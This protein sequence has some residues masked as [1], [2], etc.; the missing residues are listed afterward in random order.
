MD[1]GPMSA[2]ADPTDP[3]TDLDPVEAA[4][5]DATDAAARMPLDTPGPGCPVTGAGRPPRMPMRR[6]CP[7]DPP[8]EYR[9]LRAEAPVD[10]I[11][12]PSGDEGWLVSRLDL[13][14]EVLADPRVSHRN[15]LIEP[16]VPPQPSAPWTPTPPAPGS[17]NMMDPPEQTR[18]RKLLA[19]YF[20]SRRVAAH[21]DDT[22]RIAH[23]QL[24]ELRAQGPG[25]DLMAHYAVPLAGRVICGLL[26]V[27]D[28]E[29]AGLQRDVDTLFEITL[30]VERAIP[31]ITEF[32]AAVDR[33]VTASEKPDAGDALLADLAAREELD[34]DELRAVAGI[35]ISGGLD[36]TPG[37]LGL[38][39]LALMHHPDQVPVLLDAPEDAGWPVD[40]LLRYLTIS[41][42][43][44]S[45][46]VLEDIEVDGVTLRAGELVVLA[47][48][49]ANRDPGA[50]AEPDRLD[51]TR[52]PT[53]HVAFGHGVHQCL[54]Q[55][56]ARATLRVGW[57]TLFAAL[58][59]LAPAVDLDEV[60]LRDE[61]Q[62]YGPRELPVLWPG[63]R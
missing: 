20:S 18:L 59:D 7:F 57:R 30:T 49:A 27:P 60:S 34:G 22:R 62:H 38:G 42:W 15:D 8:E 32:G 19:R 25:A 40:E 58:P 54:G 17:F 23:E 35:L 13:V 16:V 10:R 14:R 52:R 55:H 53:Q 47:L 31:A 11:L 26:G 28:D 43:G 3:T 37:M 41:Q 24:E 2:T 5:A 45:R 6:A 56:L 9:R 29:R 44:A 4:V 48:N 36:T 46:R 51:L 63:G 12:L 39:A 1:A 50:F 61:M 33:V 21:A